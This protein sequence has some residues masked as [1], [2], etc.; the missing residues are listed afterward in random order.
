M[1][2]DEYD[3]LFQLRQGS[4]P[5]TMTEL[6]D[7]LLISRASGTR[8]VDRLIERG[9]LDRWHDDRDRRRVLVEL[10]D[11]GRRA[12]TIAGR[13]HLKGIARLV[14]TPL[15]GHDVKALA[16]ALLALE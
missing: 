5:M 9:W 12:Q 3:V 15:A 16:A 7:R 14:G 8:V 1:T 13:L 10:T 11:E 4:R 2:L 6:S